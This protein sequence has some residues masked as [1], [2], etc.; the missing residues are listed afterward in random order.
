MTAQRHTATV[1]A[2]ARARPTTRCWPRATRSRRRVA[3]CAEA[4]LSDTPGGLVGLELEF[5]LVDLVHPA[6]RP[7]WA[8]A[9]RLAEGI[10][11]LPAEQPG[12]ARAGRA[13][14]AV[15]AAAP[16]ASWPRST[17][18]RADRA[19]AAAAPARMPASARPRSAPTWPGPWPRIN[20]SPRYRA[21]EA[22]F[23][24]LGC[25]GAG[26]GDDVGHRRPAGQ[27]RRGPGGRLGRPAG[28]RPHRWCRCWWPPR[29]RRPTSAGG[30]RAGTR[31]ARAPGRASTTPAAT[32]C[33]AASPPRRGPAT[34]WTRR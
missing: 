34:R 18:L 9:Q 20:P 14:R 19:R 22:H 11:A 30:P 5:H 32:R 4:A 2:N 25:A 16:S 1:A 8:E 7:T 15:H 27:P 23:D 26:Q 12:D 24:A 31:C 13:D 21:M 29:P 33:R 17:A 3:T 28:P 6:R 10:G